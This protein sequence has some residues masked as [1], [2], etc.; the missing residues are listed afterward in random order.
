MIEKNSYLEILKDE[1]LRRVS[2]NSQYSQRAFARTLSLAPGELSE[3]MRSIR[4]LTIKSALKITKAL[5]YN[6]EEARHFVKLID[7]ESGHYGNINEIFD[8]NDMDLH[9]KS[10]THDVF[11]IVSDWYYFAIL[12]LSECDN[13][14]WNYSW[15]AKKLGLNILQVKESVEKMIR[16]GLIKKQKNTLKVN[17]DFILSP[18][19]IPSTAIRNY[20]QQMLNKALNALETQDINN[21]DITGLGLAIDPND[22]PAIK[23]D[24]SK[25]LDK[26]VKKYSND[27]QNKNKVYQLETSLFELTTGATIE[28]TH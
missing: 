15:I 9:K 28:P 1:F 26:L 7:L 13:F 22:L 24:I 19:G 8:D 10:L 3:I 6:K 2:V 12:N 18:E 25:F 23:K 20:H 5:G 16:V 11:D 21:R 14:R 4:P 27:K 17:N